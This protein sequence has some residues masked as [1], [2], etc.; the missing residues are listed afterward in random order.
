MQSKK[1][2][3]NIALFRK[4]IMG[5]WPL[6]AL[7]AFFGIF[8]PL[9]LLSFT[10][11]LDAETA[12]NALQTCLGLTPTYMI[13]MAGIS[14]IIV[15]R[16]LS[17]GKRVNMLHSM[18]VGRTALFL[19]ATASSFVICIIPY[20]AAGTAFILMCIPFGIPFVGILLTALTVIL[21]WLIFFAI[22]SFC[23]MASGSSVFMIIIYGIFNFLAAIT[24]WLLGIYSDGL[25]F[26][27]SGVW[28]D[29]EYF[30]P[31]SVL[32]NDVCISCE[33]TREASDVIGTSIEGFGLV[34]IY[35]GIALALMVINYFLYRARRSE[36]AGDTVAVK[37][38]RPIFKYGLAIYSALFIGII[39]YWLTFDAFMD[40]TMFNPL[41]IAIC[42]AVSG[43]IGYFGAEM[44]IKKRFKV[45]RGAAFIGAGVVMLF[46]LAFSFGFSLDPLKFVS[47]VPE[48]NEVEKLV[49][50]VNGVDYIIYEDEEEMLSKF[51]ELHKVIVNDKDKYSDNNYYD[52][53]GWKNIY[54]TY[55]LKNDVVL[56][57]EYSFHAKEDLDEAMKLISDIETDTQ[58]VLRSCN[59]GDDNFKLYS[60]TISGTDVNGDE[61]LN[62]LE[63]GKLSKALEEDIK[64]GCIPSN[65]FTRAYEGEVNIYIEMEFTQHFENGDIRSYSRKGIEINEKWTN[66]IAAL[67]EMQILSDKSAT[68]S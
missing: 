52:G 39:L 11:G 12:V 55:H 9:S 18:P 23:V 44:L 42:T 61:P 35:A 38:F 68:L 7:A 57:R 54:L 17:V 49:A 10:G 26:G 22:A 40:N 14:A 28:I 29:L 63:R 33:G 46:C 56:E 48:D 43:F 53:G 16:Y 41:G 19:T 32:T 64:A 20:V 45:F 4:N 25:L 51:T 31:V 58:L 8:V 36:S 13:I 21:E 30:V 3:F 6:W 60:A 5:C 2:F 15:W 65:Y 67:L 27:V 50:S 62:E 1:S 34:L 66:T 47:R 24:E 59:L 37:A